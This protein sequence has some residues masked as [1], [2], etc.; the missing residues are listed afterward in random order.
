LFC[1]SIEQCSV[2]INWCPPIHSDNESHLKIH[3][4]TQKSESA[5]YLKYSFSVNHNLL[6]ILYVYWCIVIFF[7]LL[8]QFSII[9]ILRTP[10]IRLGTNVGTVRYILVR[11]WHKRHTGTDFCFVVVIRGRV[12]AWRLV[13]GVTSLL[14]SRFSS[15]FNV[16]HSSTFLSIAVL[17]SPLAPPSISR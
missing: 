6:F 15:R 13:A 10:L 5:V 14:T 9:T 2:G 16:C 11:G 17:Y 3:A 7:I 4:R 8:F 1:G 12:L